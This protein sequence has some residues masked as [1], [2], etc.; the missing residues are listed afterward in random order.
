MVNL[1]WADIVC[2]PGKSPGVQTVFV[3]SKQSIAY[4]TQS[5]TSYGPTTSCKVNFKK[6]SS[7]PSLEMT[8]STFDVAHPKDSCKGNRG[9]YLSIGKKR[10]CAN[11]GPDGYTS[12]VKTLAVT[13]K[14]DKNGNGRGAECTIACTDFTPTATWTPWTEWT[15]CS[16]SCG[17]GS[18]LRMRAC[19]GDS[20][21][22]LGDQTE[23]EACETPACQATWTPWTEWTQCSASC[24]SGSRLRTRACNGDSSLCLGDQTET[25]ACET[26]G[27]TTPSITTTAITGLKDI[28]EGDYVQTSPPASNDWHYVSIRGQIS[29]QNIFTWKNKAGVEWDLIFIEEESSGVYKFEVGENCPYYTDGYTEARLYTN[30]RNEIEGPHGMYTKQ[31]HDDTRS[32]TEE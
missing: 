18:R 30:T 22:C 32:S 23:T 28:V 13:F 25:E 2:P 12:K 8:C 19:N 4:K 7:C 15:Q 20:S 27:T 16:A 3:G 17:F 9:D 21:L 26:P 31:N 10:F 6:M 14:S 24:G 1:G 5:R 29:S 11:K